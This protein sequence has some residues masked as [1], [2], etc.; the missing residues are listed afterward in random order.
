MH[1]KPEIKLGL[2]FNLLNLTFKWDVVLDKINKA[3]RTELAD[4]SDYKMN[5]LFTSTVKSTP[6]ILFGDSV[7]LQIL[8]FKCYDILMFPT[9]F[10]WDIP[11]QFVGL[12]EDAIRERII[13][14]VLPL[15]T[16]SKEELTT[17]LKFVKM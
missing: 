16:Q 5:R 11:N 9:L 10:P 15:V 6:D 3:N 17:L 8:P 13:E 7:I 2:G 1:E 14:A 12:S 4:L